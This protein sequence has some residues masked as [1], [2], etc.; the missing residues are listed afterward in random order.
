MESKDEDEK[1]KKQ[2]EWCNYVGI[3]LS[4]Q[5]WKYI[6]LMKKMKKVGEGSNYV[7]I[8]FTG[9]K[10]NISKRIKGIVR[11]QIMSEYIITWLNPKIHF[12][13][14]WKSGEG[15]QLY[16]NVHYLAKSKNTF[17]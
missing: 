14:K 10:R 16:W 5:I 7:G 6:I 2:W 12:F 3:Y 4:G 17:F 15:V 1:G 9:L 8:Y 13:K 11:G